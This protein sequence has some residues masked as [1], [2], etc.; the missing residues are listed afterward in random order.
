MRPLALTLS[1]LCLASPAVAADTFTPAQRMEIIR[2]VREALK[3]DPSILRDA[4]TALQAE[5]QERQT[6]ETRGKVAQHKADIFANPADPFAGDPKG[7]VTLVEFYDPRCPYCRRMLPALD[8]LLKKDT[9]L[10]LVYKDIPVLG[11][12]SN[13]EAAAIL[14]AQR[15]GGYMKMQQALMKDPATQTLATVK[16]TAARLGLD[17]AKLEADMKSADVSKQINANL[18]LARTLGVTGTPTFVIGDQV[19]PGQVDEAQL[20]AVIAEA[21]KTR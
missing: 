9:K 3:A 1:L 16:E 11:P 20:A 10:K 7:D 6:A 21:R 12:A 15:Q 2:I 8:A 19:L 5:D 4:V 14:A 18:E 13:L 17:A